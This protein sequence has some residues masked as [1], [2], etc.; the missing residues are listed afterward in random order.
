MYLGIALLALFLSVACQSIGDDGA[1]LPLNSERIEQR[2]G[3]YGVH[4][5]AQSGR[6][7]A[8]CLYSRETSGP[9]CRTVALVRFAYPEP[10][11]LEAPLAEIRAGASLG[12]TIADYGYSIT[13][14]NR[15]M[16]AVDIAQNDGEVLAAWFRLEPPVALAAH[17]YRLD[18][19]R[20]A[21]RVTVAEVLELHHPAYLDAAEV[22]SI[23]RSLPGTRDEVRPLA[24]DL[25]QLFAL[26][27]P[28][29]R[30]GNL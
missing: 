29:S 20:N 16:E 4:V 3:S 22:V 14:L 12:Q 27:A 5:I 24:A 28:P 9:V 1:R 19:V 30:I 23:Y 8:T 2:F 18:A 13:K 26:P 10:P 25:A 21:E 7:R 6:D 11:G 15:E 17:R